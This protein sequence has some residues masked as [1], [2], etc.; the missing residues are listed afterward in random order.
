MTLEVLMG[1]SHCSKVF[2]CNPVIIL[3]LIQIFL[4]TQFYVQDWY[5]IQ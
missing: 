3:M 1:L 2:G 4:G 5:T